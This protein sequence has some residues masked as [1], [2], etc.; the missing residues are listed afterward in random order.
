MKL[1]QKPP[2]YPQTIR[3]L[4]DAGEL[5]TVM[6]NSHP[7]DGRGRYLHWDDLRR[8]TPPDGLT[9]EQWW[10]SMAVARRNIARVLPLRT[11]SGSEFRFSNVDAVQEL[12]HHI[13]QQASGQILAD[14]VVTN[15]KSSDRYLVSSLVE[16]AI[17]SSQLEGAS[18]TR[19]VAKEMLQTGRPPKDRSEQMIANNYSAMLLAEE[20]ARSGAPLT[21]TDVLD[22]HRVVTEGA[23]DDP[24]DA[25]RL[26]NAH[27]ERISVRWTDDTLLHVPPPA[28]EL[29]HRLEMMCEFANGTLGDGFLHPVVRAIVLHFWLAHDHPFVDGNGR[30]S[31][32]LFYWS[33]QR[34]GYWLTQYLSISSILRKAPTQ[35]ARSYLLVETDDSDITYFVLYQL[36]VVERA[37]ES[38]KQYLSRKIAETRELGVLLR[39]ASELNHRQ[40]AILTDAIKDPSDPFTF[41]AQARRHRVTHQSARTDLLKL[42]ELGLMERSKRGKKFVFRAVEDLPVRLRDMAK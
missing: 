40:L 5:V 38:L 9:Q 39:G 19:Q 6:M 8:R 23:L 29:Q 16:E 28:T 34:S 27:E 30:T 37:I 12:V 17:T 7:V 18:T 22:L 15:L 2:D 3:R 14:D 13:D 4:S 33:M 42:E 11:S 31:R 41:A 24:L 35:Y 21:P 20:L 1:P 36:G 25:G 10:L 26:Q 32:A